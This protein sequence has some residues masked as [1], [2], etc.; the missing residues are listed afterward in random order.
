MQGRYEEALVA[1]EQSYD[2]SG[3]P[4]LLY[5][6][7][8]VHERSGDFDGV[9]LK[10]EAYLPHATDQER[11]R[12]RSRIESLRDRVARMEQRRRRELEALRR[13]GP[14]R[15][16]IS[17]SGVLLTIGAAALIGAG[18]GTAFIA[19]G[20]R[21][22]LDAQ[23]ASVA[24]RTVCPPE[25]RPVEKRDLRASLFADG[26]FIAGGLTF[27][28]GLW[29]LLRN[30][31]DSEDAPDDYPSNEADRAQVNVY[32]DGSTVGVAGAF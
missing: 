14:P 28:G 24:G 8:N 12:L 4:L 21:N 11:P 13:D 29:L 9:L 27:L 30:D 31:D 22:E 20:A 5:N 15:K 2:L 1:F 18:V 26:L 17:I 16:P 6:M 3:R 19:R 25:A 23:C 7:A 32:L 10:L